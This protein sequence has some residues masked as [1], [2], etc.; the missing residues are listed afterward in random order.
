MNQEITSF[1]RWLMLAF[2]C[3]LLFQMLFHDGQIIENMVTGSRPG[4][5]HL[6]C[7]SSTPTNP[8]GCVI[9]H[10]VAC[11]SCTLLLGSQS[12]TFHRALFSCW[13]QTKMSCISAKFEIR[14]RSHINNYTTCAEKK[15]FFFISQMNLD[16]M[17]FCSRCFASKHQRNIA[18]NSI[19]KQIDFCRENIQKSM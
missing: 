11:C 7:F 5:W 13:P 3:I 6:W 9:D 12:K 10:V 17:F 15:V 14:Q 18:F 16:S 1:C 8:F 2:N 4:V 19:E